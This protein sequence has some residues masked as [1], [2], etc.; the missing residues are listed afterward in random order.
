MNKKPGSI[1]ENQYAPSAPDNRSAKS[2]KADP[3]DG[4]ASEA[5]NKRGEME[6]SDFSH[7]ELSSLRYGNCSQ[8]ELE[9][10]SFPS[11]C[12]ADVTEISGGSE[13]EA[14]VERVPPGL[15]T[16]CQEHQCRSE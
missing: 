2:P 13:P 5:D 14:E 1:P 16:E 11:I 15:V 9:R 10:I 7:R 3:D 8:K 4:E 12:L 6:P